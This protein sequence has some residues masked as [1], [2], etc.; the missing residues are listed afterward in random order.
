MFVL[1]ELNDKEASLMRLEGDLRATESELNNRWGGSAALQEARL[2]A[3]LI[4][5]SGWLFGR[6]LEQARTVQILTHPLPTC[7]LPLHHRSREL[8]ELRATLAAD[9]GALEG[10]KKEINNT[11]ERAQKQ[12]RLDTP[13]S[14]M[15]GPLPWTFAPAS[16]D[17]D[18]E[19]ATVG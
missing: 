8:S 19:L 18:S 6:Y 3:L 12:V 5:P 10:L 9:K 16:F 2:R 4:R 13:G 15:P 17:T 7:L 14:G 11:D 1:Q